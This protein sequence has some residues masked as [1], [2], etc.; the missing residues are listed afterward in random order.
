MSGIGR[1]RLAVRRTRRRGGDPILNALY[2]GA[3]AAGG[4]PVQA[5]QAPQ[6][7]QTQDVA[8]TAAQP[9]VARDIAAFEPR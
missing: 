3:R 8:A 5:L 9:A 4:N 1:H 2:G 7:N 6:Q